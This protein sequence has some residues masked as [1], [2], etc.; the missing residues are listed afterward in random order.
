MKITPVLDTG[1]LWAVSDIFPSELVDLVHNID[2]NLVDYDR[3]SI[4]DHKRRQLHY[5]DQRDG[6][7]DHYVWNTMVPQIEHRCGVKFT[8]PSQHSFAWWL[9][10]PGFK[11]LMH[12]DGDLPTALQ[13]YWQPTDHPELGT[14]FY[15][16][17]N[18]KDLT[19]YFPSVPNTGYLM[20][21]SHNPRPL[22]WHDMQQA[23][24]AD[25]L[26]LSLYLVFGPYQL[27]S[28]K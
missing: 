18:T 23:V 2:W 20:F 3:I 15:S 13:I 14:A 22:M 11:P 5:N 7:L 24:P 12:T 10:E 25:V 6:W 28:H 1:H 17:S 9:D 19:H 27:C 8:D 16:T 26:R 21:N 4:G